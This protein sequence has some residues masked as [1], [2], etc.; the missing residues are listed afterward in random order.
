MGNTSGTAVTDPYPFKL[1]NHNSVKWDWIWSDYKS[2][3][4]WDGFVWR[5]RPPPGYANVGDKLKIGSGNAIDAK[6]AYVLFVKD[7]PK[8]CKRPIGYTLVWNDRGSGGRYNGSCWRPIPPP[9]YKAL[10]CVWMR[11]YAKPSVNLVRCVHQS[12]VVKSSAKLAQSW[13]DNGSGASMNLNGLYNSPYHTHS[14]TQ[15]KFPYGDN[16]YMIMPGILRRACC[17]G[18]YGK[19]QIT[20]ELCGP[21]Q[22]DGSNCKS[23]NREHCKT[24]LNYPFC[25]EMAKLDTSGYFDSSVDKWCSE[26]PTSEFCN[27]TR[28]SEFIKGLP[29]STTGERAIKSH[30][31]C[32][33]PACKT[34]AQYMTKDQHATKGGSCPS[35][36]ICTQNISTRDQTKLDNSLIKQDCSSER[37]T[38][39]SKPILSTPGTGP[40]TTA[41][42]NQTNQLRQSLENAGLDMLFE[43]S[44]FGDGTTVVW[45]HLLVLLLIIF[46]IMRVTKSGENNGQ[47]YRDSQYRDSL[48]M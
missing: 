30:P 32:Y 18:Q 38:D 5:P 21:F 6:R 27:C 28:H 47:R 9:G 41:P 37:K 46:I 8:H 44:P 31:Q 12:L 36:V 24:H 20:P 14:S 35:L 29:E 43:P 19:G 3:A 15:S 4:S 17:Q 13:R 10:G 1:I 26:N 33:I 34:P 16:Q 22:P 25:Q 11:S 48:Y 2:G 45:K 40:L 23:F 39:P 42:S 7:E